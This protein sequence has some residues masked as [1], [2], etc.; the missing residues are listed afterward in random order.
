MLLPIS[1][2]TSRDE[3]SRRCALVSGVLLVKAAAFESE[4][5]SLQFLSKYMLGCSMSLWRCRGI[6]NDR[7]LKADG[8]EAVGFG[9]GHKPLFPSQMPP[10]T[11]RMLNTYTRGKV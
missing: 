5:R 10:V 6:R 4:L 2:L 7:W 1:Y 3:H 11:F 9:E 8:A